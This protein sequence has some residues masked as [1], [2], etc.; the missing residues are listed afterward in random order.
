MEHLLVGHVGLGWSDIEYFMIKSKSCHKKF[1]Q[2]FFF[3]ASS[4]KL[5]ELKSHH[6][7]RVL[8]KN[9]RF[10]LNIHISLVINSFKI[11]FFS[12]FY[13]APSN[14]NRCYMEKKKSVHGELHL[15]TTGS[16]NVKFV[17]L[18]H[19]FSRALNV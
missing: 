15:G 2:Y 12:V 5:L 17:P 3:F 13:L 14:A 6:F 16:N 18:L 4:L 8:L 19:D 10:S 11:D 7:L 1:T 9:Y